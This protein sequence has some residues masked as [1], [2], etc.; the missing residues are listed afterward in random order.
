MAFP[1]SEELYNYDLYPKVV[2]AG[3]PVTVHIRNLGNR[4]CFAPGETV[5]WRLIGMEGGAQEVYPAS[6]DEVK[7]EMVCD[8]AGAFDFTHTFGREQEYTLVARYK[9]FYGQDAE[10]C[11]H[12]FCVAEDL[13]GRY[14]LMGDLHMHTCRS[15]GSQTPEVVSAMYRAHGYDFF[16]ITDHHRYYPSLEAIRFY[17]DLPIEFLIVPGE[18]VHMPTVNGWWP[19]GHIVNFGGEYSVNAMVEDVQT[20]EVGT[21][22][23]TRAI[24]EDCP[25][26]MTRAEYEAKMQ[27]LA[28]ATVVPEGVDALPVAVYRFVY[29]E[30]RKAGGLGIFAHPRW[31]WDHTAHVPDPVND[32]LVENRLFDAFEVLGGERYYEHNGFQTQR[33]YEDRARGYRYPVVGSTDSHC[34]Y[35]YNPCAFICSTIVFSPEIERKAIIRSIKDFYSVAVDT[36]SREFRL[37]GEM[38]LCRYA[39]FL[40]KYYFPLHDELC[41]E[42]GMQMKRYATGTPEE[43][44]QAKKTLA[45]LYGR[46]AALRKKY[47]DF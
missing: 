40:L 3:K 20:Q 47:F 42:E 11:L 1:F 27:A 17:Q 15:D 39:C 25:E 4:P 35:D 10:L 9:N 2:V 7:L 5:T 37:V 22:K 23:S 13:A 8:G 19:S 36:I 28:D 31:L 12:L 34:C 6:A 29:D 18:E 21:D 26:V 45:C 43:K 33:Y 32:Y 16:A 38:R 14:P 46:V 24:R 44:E 30:I 41:R